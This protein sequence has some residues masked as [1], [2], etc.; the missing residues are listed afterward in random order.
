MCISLDITGP[1]ARLV[2]DAPDRR[3]VLSLKTLCALNDALSSVTTDHDGPV[4]H[5]RGLGPAFCAG[6]D[7]RSA[8]GDGAN[9]QAQLTAL[10]ESVRRLKRLRQVV[11]GEARG[12]AIA[13]GC[14]LLSACDFVCVAPS[15]RIGYP[16]VTLGV[17]PAITAP[18][19]VSKIGAQRT[20]E[21]LLGARL[22]DGTQAKRIG[23]AHALAENDEALAELA[24]SIC[25]KLLAK[26][27]QALAATKAWMN[28][29]EDAASD[30]RF[31]NAL[32]TS[33]NTAM[34]EEAQTRIASFWS[35]FDQKKESS[36]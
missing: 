19:L 2:L 3:N 7:T 14:A 24:E 10:S 21:L 13:G 34:S 5:L 1:I 6:L 20:R 9:L 28:I 36:T 12:A 30:T 25:K 8:I 26:G 29:L 33:N 31:D 11:V 32:A 22:I 18:S 15:T 35:N 23:L 4:V 16:V 17:S 27:P